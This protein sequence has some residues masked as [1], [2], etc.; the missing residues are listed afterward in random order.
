M[1]ITPSSNPNIGAWY[2]GPPVASAQGYN[3]QTRGFQ[4]LLASNYKTSGL[5]GVANTPQA[6]ASYGMVPQE[7]MD[8]YYNQ[9][10]DYA[11][12]QAKGAIAS[13]FGE[14]GYAALGNGPQAWQ[15]T[16][17][18][19]KIGIARAGANVQNAQ[20]GQ[21]A[22]TRFNEANLNRQGTIGQ[23]YFSQ[24]NQPLQGYYNAMMS[25][26]QGS[27]GAQSKAPQQSGGGASSTPWWQTS[28][29]S[30]A[31]GQSGM[32]AQ[33][34]GND[35]QTAQAKALADYL[36]GSIPDPSSQPAPNTNYW[37]NPVNPYANIYP[38]TPQEPSNNM[39]YGS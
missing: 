16:D 29:Q 6:G 32:N 13:Q 19:Q 24:L 5:E 30:Q 20:Q 4:D 37:Q 3:T 17:A 23:S 7:T 36:K 38:G 21:Q 25:G 31:L 22:Q 18:A 28:Y 26:A 12:K 39:S 15:N 34:A 11:Q 8:Q 2:A 14:S 9:A 35:A 33:I 1:A 10:G 27:G